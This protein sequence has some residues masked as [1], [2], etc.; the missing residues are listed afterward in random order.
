MSAGERRFVRTDQEKSGK[1][2]TPQHP[3]PPCTDPFTHKSRRDLVSAEDEELFTDE[4]ERDNNTKWPSN[5]RSNSKADRREQNSVVCSLRG[6]G[7]RKRHG[8]H[9]KIHGEC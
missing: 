4:R 6:R 3:D 1:S 9:I 7:K 8:Q 5:Y 2:D